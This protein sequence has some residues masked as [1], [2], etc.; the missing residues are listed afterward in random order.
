[1]IFGL[2][3]GGAGDTLMTGA[4]GAEKP[5]LGRYEIEKELGRGAM[6]VVYR[7]TDPRINRTVAIKTMALAQ[8]FE[9]SGTGRGQGTLLQAKPKPQ[10]V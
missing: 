10:A 6:G 9:E 1:M 7:G 8:E 2:R 3:S 4:L 5:M